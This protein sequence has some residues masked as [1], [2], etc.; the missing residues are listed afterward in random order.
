MNQVQ[1]PRFLEAAG[2]TFL[3]MLTALAVLLPGAASAASGAPGVGPVKEFGRFP[4]PASFPCEVIVDH[5]GNLW[6][7]QFTGNAMGEVD[8][9]TGNITEVPLPTLGG[10]P[11]GQNLGP[12]GNI[13]FVEV[14]GNSI[15]VLDP[16]THEIQTH[17]FPWANVEVGLP[18][19]GSLL[20]NNGLGV[21]FDDTF[22][23]DGKLYFTMIGLNAIGSYDIK[24][25]EWA[26]YPI[27]TPLSGPIAMERGPD[28]TVA[29]TEGVSGKIA[30]FHTDS[31]TWSEYTIPTLLSLP[32]GLTVSPD[33]KYL[34]FGETLGQK[35]GRLEPISG[36]IKE[37]PLPISLSLGNPLPSPGQLRFGSDGKLYIM[38]GTFDAGNRIGQLDVET[39]AY[40]Y[41]ETPTPLSSPC[42][43]N[44]A[45]PG[46]IIFGEFTGNRIGYF[47]I[48]N[49]TDV[50]GAIPPYNE[51]VPDRFPSGS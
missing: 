30:L 19:T 27:P 25:G 51:G 32:G 36:E 48:P 21:P 13:Y 28:E 37:F 16:E 18:S 43:L 8:P 33:G 38:E 23:A 11:G 45:L 49:T 17:P 22:G 29:I 42:D 4:I 10:Q 3:G 24:T 31:H 47:S 9:A 46:K 14:G 6:T 34:Y 44:N 12:E 7:D 50:S 5:Q 2:L 40:H 39:G 41:L 15:G 1:K 26:K 35:V 20:L